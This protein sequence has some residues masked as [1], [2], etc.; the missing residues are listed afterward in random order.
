MLRSIRRKHHRQQSEPTLDYVRQH[1]HEPN[2]EE[3][4]ALTE[5]A[6]RRDPDNIE[7]LPL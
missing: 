1:F 2:P 7:V 4:F 6:F 3:A 5:K